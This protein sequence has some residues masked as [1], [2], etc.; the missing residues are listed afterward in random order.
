MFLH[1]NNLTTGSLS[2]RTP[3]NLVVFVP[4][5]SPFIHI[6][7][8]TL[9]FALNNMYLFKVLQILSLTEARKEK[10]GKRVCAYELEKNNISKSLFRASNWRVNTQLVAEEAVLWEA[11]LALDKRLAKVI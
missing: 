7:S 5:V 11:A 1:T 3:E 6:S 2:L 10:E 4:L 8:F 9:Y